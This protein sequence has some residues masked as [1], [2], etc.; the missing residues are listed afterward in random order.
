[1]VKTLENPAYRYPI[2]F[3][4]VFTRILENNCKNKNRAQV[5]LH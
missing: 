1:M 2:N 4:I 3:F 5:Q